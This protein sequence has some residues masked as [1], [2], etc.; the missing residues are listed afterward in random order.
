MCV[1]LGVCAIE[2][3]LD[4]EE[5]NMCMKLCWN[6]IDKENPN[7]IKKPALVPLFTPKMQREVA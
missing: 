1:D 6:D 5:C 4:N 3:C 7:S 2:K